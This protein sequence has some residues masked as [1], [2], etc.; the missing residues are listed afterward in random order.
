MGNYPFSDKEDQKLMEQSL[1]KSSQKLRPYFIYAWEDILLSF[2][3]WCLNLIGL[4]MLIFSLASTSIATWAFN[5]AIGFTGGAA[6]TSGCHA[7]HG[8][9]LESWVA[10]MDKLGRRRIIMDRVNDEP[11]LER[12]YIF[13]KDRIETFPFN[14]F[15]HKFLKSDP[16]DLHD[17]PWGFFTF[18][19]AGGY[20]EYQ[21]EDEPPCKDVDK[22]VVTDEAERN[23]VK[24]WRGPGF[25]QSVTAHHTHRIEI[26]PESPACWTLFVPRLRVQKWGFFKNNNWIEADQYLAERKKK[27]K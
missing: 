12:Y 27:F 11:Y 18:I 16:D 24:K 9:V 8:G 23:V 2:G 10:L 4:F 17:H 3:N 19:I 14:I 25:F 5:T 13:M 7:S 21:C 1:R 15:I 6:C 22:A 20:W 26:D